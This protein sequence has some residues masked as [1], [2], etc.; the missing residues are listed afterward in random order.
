[1][2]SMSTDSK[3]WVKI[4]TALYILKILR[5]GPAYGNKIAE[6]I[7]HRTDNHIIL[8]PNFLYPLLRAMEER[9]CVVGRWND[10]DRRAKR[11]YTITETGLASISGLEN[12]AAR[13]FEK[14]ENKIRILRQ[15]LLQSNE[16]VMSE[17]KKSSQ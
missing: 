12:K 13:G 9:G 5:N 3:T 11:I 15:D 8:N 10:P 1:M 7:K 2:L 4:F 14:L 6:E 17:R 16:V